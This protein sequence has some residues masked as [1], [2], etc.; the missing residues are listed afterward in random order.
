[1]QSEHPSGSDVRVRGDSRIR[2]IIR[3]VLKVASDRKSLPWLVEDTPEG[4]SRFR[5]QRLDLIHLPVGDCENVPFHETNARAEHK[6]RD[7]SELHAQ[8]E[9]VNALPPL[10]IGSSGVRA[11]CV[12]T[13]EVSRAGF[14]ESIESIIRIEV[15]PLLDLISESLIQ[16]IVRLNVL[17]A[18][19]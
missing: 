18:G 14:R 4:P 19:I 13:Q 5:A 8:I 9:L 11:V 7:L 1:M 15:P 2:S 10:L 6:P 3:D 17:S 16:H 12:T